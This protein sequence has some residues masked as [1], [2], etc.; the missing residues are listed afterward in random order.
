MENPNRRRGRNTMI[1]IADAIDREVLHIRYEFM[2]LKGLAL[3][4]A[5]ISHRHALSTAHASALL[6]GLEAEGFL[7]SGPDGAYRRSTPPT[8]A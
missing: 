4:V 5:Q 7:V 2:A 3:T 6:E 8:S 1:T